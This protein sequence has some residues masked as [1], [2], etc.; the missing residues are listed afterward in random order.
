MHHCLKPHGLAKACHAPVLVHR[1][2][3]VICCDHLLVTC[4]R[5]ILLSAGHSLSVPMPLLLLLHMPM[6][7]LQGL[8]QLQQE[9]LQQMVDQSLI[10][11]LRQLELEHL[12]VLLE[13][14][15]QA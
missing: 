3:G 9:L 8:R 7:S 2:H 4:S 10:Q 11:Q 1:C 6:V 13:W 15:R 12:Q 14:R 5:V